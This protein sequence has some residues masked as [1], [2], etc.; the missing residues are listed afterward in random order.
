MTHI[1]ITQNRQT[2]TIIRRCNIT[3][4]LIEHHFNMQRCGNKTRTAYLT[5]AGL[6]P[7]L[8][9]NKESHR[10]FYGRPIKT[11]SSC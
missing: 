2:A 3:T 4:L 8:I 7:P 11:A 1:S 9:T 5:T 10:K 6:F